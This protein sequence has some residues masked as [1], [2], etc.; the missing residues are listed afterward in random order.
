MFSQFTKRYRI[1]L[2]LCIAIFVLIS[3]FQVLYVDQGLIL[4]E[5]K[6]SV[7][8]IKQSVE[9]IETFW[10]IN[11]VIQVLSFLFHIAAIYANR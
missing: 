1:Y 2:T 7:N 9:T 10:I 11:F 4:S 3:C 5:I 6:E 8:T